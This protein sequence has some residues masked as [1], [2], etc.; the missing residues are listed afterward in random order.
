[1][2]QKVNG[3]TVAIKADTSGV[4]AGLKDLTTQSVSLTKQLKTV[5]S[6]LDMD[7]GN[8]ELI[9]TKQ[10]LLSESAETSRKKLEA[11]K[12]AQ[13]DVEKAFQ[14]GDL[15]SAEYV[16]FQKEL[17]QTGSRLRDLEAQAEDTGEE[18][19]ELGDDAQETGTQL[20]A[21]G[22]ESSGLGDKLKT[23]LAAGAKAAAAA[24]AAVTAAAAA[25]VAA[26]IDATGE[27]AEYGDNIDKMSQKLGMSAQ[28]YQEWDFIMQHAGSDIDKMQ[29]SMKVLSEAVVDQS[30]K[31]VAAFAKLGISMEDAANMSQEE[32]FAATVTA[33]QG[34]ESGA[35]RTALA[36]DLLGKSAM[37]L[38]ALLNTS[39]EETEAMRQQVH[40]LGGVMS[41]DAVKASAAY[42]D[43][44]QNVK[45]A[46]SSF[47][48]NVGSSFLPA[49]TQ[50]MDG[51]S[52][53]V[54]G[55][56]EAVA[57]IEGGLQ[58]FVENAEQTADKIAEA[59][60][61]FVPIIV[62]VVD[63][64]LPKLLAAAAKIVG[65][66]AN[67]ILN[68]LPVILGTGAAIIAN[69]AESLV[70]ALPQI[71]RTG[72]SVIAQLAKGIADALPT[73][74]PTII[75]ITL[76]I[77]D[78]L[79]D[80]ATLGTLIDASLAII[81][82]LSDG[83][84]ESLPTLIERLPEIVDNIVTGIIDALP[85]LLDAAEELVKK[86]GA[87]LFNPENAD[88]MLTA[89]M[90][91]I[92]KIVKGIGDA[93][94]KIGVKC[95]E[96]AKEIADKIG[97]GEYWEAGADVIEQ[98]MGGVTEKW[99][100]WRS[101]WEGF[102]EYIFDVLHPGSDDGSMIDESAVWTP[103]E[104]AMA[105]GGIVT[106]PTR[107]LIGENGRELILPL[108]RNTG[109]MDTLA[110]KIGGGGI[111][112]GNVQI[113]VPAGSDGRQIARSFVAELDTQLRQYQIAQQRG[114]GGTAWPT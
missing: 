85:K 43:S 88:K 5:D 73:L 12:A 4:S 25:T 7:P 2:A 62:E 37:D 95:A 51:F 93:L 38:G 3:I 27:T 52:A 74:V 89:G 87:Y 104:P 1:M 10:R 36:T 64:S 100:E 21:A 90:D 107:A 79:T 96:I 67:G 41:D 82:A 56:D 84:I 76:E 94:W 54:A 45:T 69:L 75:D 103:P 16:A 31:S 46:I 113:T 70:K 49:I 97:L 109:W 61:R 108:D 57:G 40:D 8:T 98:F 42:Q 20:K 102:G 83:I 78:I 11:L 28:S 110:A 112:I 15:G 32:L 71:V 19:D 18:I 77:V 72:I 23:G 55:D 14:K 101:W 17:V 34:M 30:D 81:L 63:R 111:T 48:R 39:A 6:L 44:L 60:E 59:A 99:N 92:T 22:D 106:R 86:L 33:L 53:L 13:E 68:N 66:I 80:P 26:I 114:I 24:L 91:I 50:M 9:A 65:K 35:E 29:T 105:V 47:G 58:A